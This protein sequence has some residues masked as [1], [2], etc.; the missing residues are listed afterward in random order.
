MKKG[1]DKVDYAGTSVGKWG[2]GRTKCA[3]RVN[4][5]SV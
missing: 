1:R 3:S 2:G 5:S 4:S